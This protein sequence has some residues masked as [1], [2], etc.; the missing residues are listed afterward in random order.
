MRSRGLF[1]SVVV[2]GSLLAAALAAT[3]GEVTRVSNWEEV[4]QQLEAIALAPID[5]SATPVSCDSSMDEMLYQE[6]RAAWRVRGAVAPKVVKQ[7]MFDL[8][9]D[10]IDGE[11]VKPLAEKLGVQAVLIGEATSFNRDAR[12]PIGGIGKLPEAKVRLRLLRSDGMRLLE[13]ERSHAALGGLDFSA[14]LKPLRVLVK[15]A[16]SAKH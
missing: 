1:I 13:G 12:D 14:I 6:F 16:F 8:G 10:H 9:I 11:T 2:A 4:S 15:E 3:A 7:A 5:C